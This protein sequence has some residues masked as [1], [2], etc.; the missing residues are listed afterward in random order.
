MW[1][2]KRLDL[3]WGDLLAAAAR[4][5]VSRDCDS[6]AAEIEGQWSPVGDAVACLS[7]RSAFDLLLAGLALPRGSE[8]LVSAVTISGMLRIIEA[9]GLVAVPVDL[10]EL[11][12]SPRADALARG[13][14]PRTRAVLV[15]HL[16]GGRI[17]LRP[18]ADFARRHDLLLVEDAAQA[19]AGPAYTG[20]PAADVS[21]YSFG[22]IKTATALGGGIARVCDRRLLTRMREI[23][24]GWLVQSHCTFVARAIKYAALKAASSRPLYTALLTA[25]RLAGRD[26]DRIV[27]GSVRGFSNRDFFARIRQ[28]PSA[29]LLSLLKRRL[30]RFDDQRIAQRASRA[31]QIMAGMR[32]TAYFPGSACEPHT[33]WL[34][35]T[36]SADPRRLIQ[37]LSSKGFDATQGQ[38]LVVVP[39]PDDRPE[40]DPV[41]AR[42][43]LSGI[44]FLPCYADMNNR[45]IERLAQIVAH[46]LLSSGNATKVVL[47]SSCE[48][49]TQRTHRLLTANPAVYS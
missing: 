15:A 40:L 48:G 45:A 23:H 10:D 42:K 32:G 21:L 26:H 47:P 18:I 9:H 20:H 2:R 34:L 31:E 28:R 7:V 17:D 38:S 44:V 43:V 19:Y 33:H 6:L 49:S 41:V 12:M 46:E 16:F 3:G 11:T 36:W 8:V 35:P 30:I 22:P 37:L 29:P 39:M 14:T 4:T 13:L 1:S 5:I 24:T 25:C 27:N